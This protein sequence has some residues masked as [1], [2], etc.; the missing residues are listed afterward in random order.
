MLDPFCDC[1]TTV[2]AAEKLG[3]QWIG[4][5]VTHL[6]IGLIEKRLRDAFPAVQFTTHGVP[7]DIHAARDLAAQGKYHEFGKCALSLIAAQPGNFCKKGAD[8]GL[9]GR[10]YLGPRAPRSLSSPSRRVRTSSSA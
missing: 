8:R 2:H 6:A 9:D 5:D 4:I 1:G 10:L 3:R 7:Q